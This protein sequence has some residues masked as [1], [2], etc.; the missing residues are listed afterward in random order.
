MFVGLIHSSISSTCS[1]LLRGHVPW[2]VP[3]CDSIEPQVTERSQAALH[4][5]LKFQPNLSVR[6]FSPQRVWLRCLL[7]GDTCSTHVPQPKAPDNTTLPESFPHPI[8]SDP[9]RVI[10]PNRLR[11]LFW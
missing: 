5:H 2:Q 7:P 6:N 10:K 11:H 9:D 4:N 8:L 3:Q 1:S